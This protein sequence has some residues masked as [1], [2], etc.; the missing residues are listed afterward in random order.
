M[1]MG[2]RASLSATSA[3]KTGTQGAVTARRATSAWGPTEHRLH[4]Q[5][6]APCARRPRPGFEEKPPIPTEAY[7]LLLTN[8]DDISADL[9]VLEFQRRSV[10]Y[11]RFNTEDFP[12][13]ARL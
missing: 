2:L 6:L 3:M 7:S 13:R 5:Q 10:P 9:V 1:F 11:L 8:R 4:T 12:E